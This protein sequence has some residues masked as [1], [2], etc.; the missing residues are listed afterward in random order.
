MGFYC[1][2][3]PNYSLIA[4]PLIDLTK[5]VT[6]F[7]WGPTQI[8]AFKTL[9]TLMC[10]HPVLRQPDY[11]KPF[12]ISTNASGYG[13]GAIL[14][15]EGELNPRTK[16]PV[17]Q[18]I[19]YYSAT[20][21]PTERNYDIYERELLAVIKSLKHWRPHVAATEIPVMVLTDHANLLYWKS[22]C[23]V[24][25]RVARWF[26]TLQDYNIIIKHV[27]GKIHATPDMLSRP[28]GTD[29]GENDNQ[30][31]TL[32]QPTAFIRLAW[33]R[34]PEACQLDLDLVTAQHKHSQWIKNLREDLQT[35]SSITTNQQI[36]Y[37]LKEGQQAVIPP[38]DK[39]KHLILKIHHDD[40][41]SGHLG[42]D[43]T[44]ESVA[45]R[46]WWPGMR[47]WIAQYVKGCAACQQNKPKTTARYN[48]NHNS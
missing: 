40:V 31:L 42:R 5:K 12:F 39:L 6:P 17:Q 10:R 7:H 15:Q 24:N 13:V 2:F 9:K 46:H 21:S 32:L 1:Y 28:P 33:D 38:D 43:Q 36:V 34:S 22:P 37:R 14:S 35:L 27:P 8:K 41:T 30:D 26:G 18:P 11:N 25:R 3:V 45:I 47:T 23:K 19:A 20:F 44:Y 4:R 48:F 29:K 16:K